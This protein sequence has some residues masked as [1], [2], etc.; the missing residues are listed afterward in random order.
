MPINNLTLAEIEK[1]FIYDI[2]EPNVIRWKIANSNCIN[3]NSIAGTLSTNGYVVVCLNRKFFGVHRIIYQIVNNID[4][5]DFEIDHIDGDKKNNNPNNL[6]PANRST[7]MMNIR[8]KGLNTS[9]KYKGVSYCKE[10]GRWKCRIRLNY[11]LIGLGYFGNEVDAA[12]AYDEKATELFGEYA[13]LNFPKI[14]P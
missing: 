12:I 13:S 14:I 3:V 10:K 11:R 1:Y 2:N 8:K 9:S 5:L 7:N 4:R 6:R